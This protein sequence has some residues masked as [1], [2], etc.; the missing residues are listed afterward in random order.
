MGDDSTKVSSYLTRQRNK[1]LRNINY[2]FV[3]ELHK[4][5]NYAFTTTYFAAPDTA[6]LCATHT[7]KSGETFINKGTAALDS[8]AVDAALEAGAL[9]ADGV[10][11][12]MGISYDTI[13]VRKGSEAARTAR[14]L[15][16]EKIVPTAVADINI[17]EGEFRIIETPYI[18]NANKL[19]WFMFDTTKEE[20]PLYAVIMKSP[21]FSEPKMQDNEAIRQNVEG[22]WK[23][24]IINMPYAVYG[25]T[26]AA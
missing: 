21:Y 10:G 25:S 5:F 24:G 8:A 16:A 7:W 17:Y 3:T 22:F 2:L 23:Q 19:T 12:E 1:C 15:F 20:S 26:G 18:T 14:K 6:A 13:V 11:E 4:F 9:I